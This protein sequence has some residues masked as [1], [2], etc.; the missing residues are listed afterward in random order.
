MVVRR[1]KYQMLMGQLSEPCLQNE[2]QPDRP[3]ELADAS[4]ASVDRIKLSMKNL[5]PPLLIIYLAG[6]FEDDGLELM[7]HDVPVLFQGGTELTSYVLGG[8]KVNGKSLGWALHD[9][10]GKYSDIRVILF[11]PS[12]D[13]VSQLAHALRICRDAGCGSVEVRF[14]TYEW[15]ETDGRLH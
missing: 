13:D 5:V 3:S 6:C 4:P 12:D 14:N 9:L 1:Q 15:P 2:F 11:A 8:V 10:A 7:K